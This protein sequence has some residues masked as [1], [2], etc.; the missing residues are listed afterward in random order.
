MRALLIFGAFALLF[1]EPALAEP[2]MLE[3]DLPGAG[4]PGIDIGWGAAWQQLGARRLF[5]LQEIQF[6]F[7][8]DIP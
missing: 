3:C 1:A 2:I 6:I 4:T 7:D 5:I 8:R